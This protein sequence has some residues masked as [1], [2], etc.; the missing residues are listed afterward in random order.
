MN[1]NDNVNM[2]MGDG[3]PKLSQIIDENETQWRVKVLDGIG[4]MWFDKKTLEGD[5]P[6]PHMVPH[7]IAPLD[8]VI[9]DKADTHNGLIPKEWDGMFAIES[10]EALIATLEHANTVIKHMRAEGIVYRD[11]KIQRA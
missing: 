6:N 5:L 4:N 2:I 7:R 10:E 11:G 9:P 1:I 3:E 8:E